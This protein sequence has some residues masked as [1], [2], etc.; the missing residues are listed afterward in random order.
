[1]DLKRFTQKAKDALEERGGTDGLKDDVGRAREAASTPGSIKDKALAVKEALTN[2]PDAEADAPAGDA[3][4]SGDAAPATEKTP[5][6][7]A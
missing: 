1:M 7:A 4:T 6:S 2:R 3:P 5:P